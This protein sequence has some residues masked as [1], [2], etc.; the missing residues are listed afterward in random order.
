MPSLEPYQLATVLFLFF[1]ERVFLC[2]QAIALMVVS[3]AL[4][5]CESFRECLSLFLGVQNLVT[6]A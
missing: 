2:Y 6:C 4:D 5:K 1:T 3:E